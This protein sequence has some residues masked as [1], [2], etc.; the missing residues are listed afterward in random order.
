[1]TDRKRMLKQQYLAERRRRDRD[2]IVL[3]DVELVSWS[4]PGQC[5]R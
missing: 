5:S 2:L 3:T 1:M 4:T